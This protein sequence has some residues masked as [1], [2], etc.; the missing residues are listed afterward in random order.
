MASAGDTRPEAG[1]ADDACVDVGELLAA[2]GAAKRFG[3]ATSPLL[4]DRCH[5]S[6]ELVQV[7][8]LNERSVAVKFVH[9]LGAERK[10]RAAC[11]DGAGDAR[12]QRRQGADD[13]AGAVGVGDEDRDAGA[14]EGGVYVGD[15]DAAGDDNGGVGAGDGVGD[16]DAGWG[17]GSLAL[18]DA[19]I[20]APVEVGV[21]GEDPPPGRREELML[22]PL[23][24]VVDDDDVGADGGDA[25][26]DG[27]VGVDGDDVVADPE[28][29][30]PTPHQGHGRDGRGENA[31]VVVEGEGEV[32][33]VVDTV[34][35]A[36][37][38]G[39]D[40]AVGGPAV[41]DVEDDGHRQPKLIRAMGWMFISGLSSW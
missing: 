13:D 16:I 27:A 40:G 20:E 37:V 2:R 26:G 12:R 6:D 36:D 31:V 23:V 10:H 34:E 18:G 21:A 1:G 15:G 41:D 19:A 22:G 32:G 29:P 3:E 9:P 7:A 8:H 17:E 24:G 38:V 11:S 4:A 25:P 5:R 28:L 33:D 39:D 30:Q 14:A 35:G